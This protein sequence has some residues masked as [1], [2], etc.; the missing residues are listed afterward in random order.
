MPEGIKYNMVAIADLITG[1]GGTDIPATLLQPAPTRASTDTAA[2]QTKN[3]LLKKRKTL[4][5]APGAP[6]NPTV[7]RPALGSA[8]TLGAT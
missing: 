3:T 4:L 7:S 5:T 6:F 1:G 8:V 2:Q